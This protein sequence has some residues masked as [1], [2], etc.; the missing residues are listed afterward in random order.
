MIHQ[1]NKLALLV[2][3]IWAAGVAP[4]A[5][6]SDAPL[7]P[8]DS[9]L[10]LTRWAPGLVW[11][12]DD[13]P[14]AQAP[15]WLVAPDTAVQEE[16]GTALVHPEPALQMAAPSE[17][18][19]RAAVAKPKGGRT[20]LQAAKLRAGGQLQRLR[21]FVHGLRA[22]PQA[23][24]AI[25]AQAPR[26][27]A[28][29]AQ[30]IAGER[31]AASQ[32]VASPH[33]D[34]LL[35]DLAAVLPQEAATWSRETVLSTVA[36][37][38][39]AAI[40]PDAFALPPAEQAAPATPGHEARP[41]ATPRREIVVASHTDKV[42]RQLEAVL[43]KDSADASEPDEMIVATQAEKVLAMLMELP[44]PRKVKAQRDTRQPAT[45]TLRA[46]AAAAAI[47]ATAEPL[48]AATPQAL[49]VDIDLTR[50]PIA[51]LIVE[52]IAEPTALAPAA[53]AAL[54]AQRTAF[55]GGEA[56]AMSESSLD[57]VRGGFVTNGL[58]ISFGIERAVYVNGALLTTTSLNVSDLGRISGGRGTAA[59][60][61]GTLALIQSGAGNV[62]AAGSL[63]ATSLGTVIQNTLDGQKIQNVTTINATVNSLGVLRGLNLQSSLRGA[64]IDSLRR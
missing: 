27:N 10:D 5:Q 42:L 30:F 37:R 48:S 50:P 20:T 51:E 61:T 55:A 58:N 6:A 3:I 7:T 12:S 39:P 31:V 15:A 44:A 52:P 22:Q 28:A 13:H 25:A 40:G 36:E 43:T 29:K 62:V 24:V 8:Q 9:A 23:A 16:P 19:P 34:R 54:S 63:S 46:E 11:R 64:V 17:P 4:A 47:V 57:R 21:S 38:F 53:P 14:A 2:A 18:A 41:R 56:L 32:Q 33:A 1:P 49:A 35:Q 59:V 60:D 26:A 45:A